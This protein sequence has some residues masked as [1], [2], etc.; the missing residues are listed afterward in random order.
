[1]PS[2]YEEI[3]QNVYRLL[4]EEHHYIVEEFKK[5]ANRYCVT[6]MPNRF[7]SFAITSNFIKEVV[8]RTNQMPIYRNHTGRFFYQYQFIEN[9][10]VK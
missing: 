3:L 1:M 9:W 4:R 8:V 7:Q 10:C 6:K 5:N 2:K